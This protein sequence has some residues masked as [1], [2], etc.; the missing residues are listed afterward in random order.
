MNYKKNIAVIP[1]RSGSK[2]LRDKNI[3]MFAGKPL[4][5]HTIEAAQLSEEFDEV[6][7][8]T[9]SEL[10]AEIAR[11]Y[12]ALVPRLRHSSLAGDAAASW[13]VVREAISWVTSEPTETLETV[14]LLQPTSPLRRADDIRSAFELFRSR[15]AD[16]VVSVCELEHPLSWCRRLG[17]DRNM[18][19]FA[20]AECGSRRQDLETAYRINGG[21]YIVSIDKLYAEGGI[22]GSNS[23]AYLM[24]RERSLDIDD[25]YDFVSAEA[26]FLERAKDTRVS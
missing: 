18:S 12:G 11:S 8:S 20:N 26:V 17:S 15:N 19:D 24:P 9:D 22:Y 4:M 3:K 7:V 5:A 14:T 13:D 6:V 16:A 25:I 23:F 1:A 10:Y 21:I 2:G